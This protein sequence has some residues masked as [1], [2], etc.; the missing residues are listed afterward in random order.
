MVQNSLRTTQIFLVV[1][2]IMLYVLHIIL[3]V[4]QKGRCVVAVLCLQSWNGSD[5]LGDLSNDWRIVLK[6][7]LQK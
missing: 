3:Y 4:L 2:Y 1:S 6:L 7:M 5:D